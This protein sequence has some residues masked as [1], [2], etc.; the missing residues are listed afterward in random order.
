MSPKRTRTGC[1]NWR[2]GRG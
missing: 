2:N 1:R